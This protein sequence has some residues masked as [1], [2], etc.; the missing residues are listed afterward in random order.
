MVIVVLS[1]Y[2]KSI[3]GQKIFEYFWMVRLP[4]G[5]KVGGGKVK[6]ELKKFKKFVKFYNF[7][8]HMP[9]R[10]N[11]SHQTELQICHEQKKYSFTIFRLTYLHSVLTRRNSISFDIFFILSVCFDRNTFIISQM[12]CGSAFIKIILV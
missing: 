12:R 1:C 8:S 10:V 3:F 9:L 2:C 5:R 7:S 4:N 11:L 6:F